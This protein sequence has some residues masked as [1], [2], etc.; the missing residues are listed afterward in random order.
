[1]PVSRQLGLGVRDPLQGAP[2]ETRAAV[3]VP[4]LAVSVAKPSVHGVAQRDLQA[5]QRPVEG[6]ADRSIPDMEPAGLFPVFL[7]SLGI[8]AKARAR[9]EDLEIVEDF[10]LVAEMVDVRPPA[11][12]FHLVHP[13]PASATRYAPGV[14]FRRNCPSRRR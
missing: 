13:G 2:V 11:R 4:G 12:H 5:L 9:E 8:V 6:G 3:V 14:L 7:N 10:V 1:M